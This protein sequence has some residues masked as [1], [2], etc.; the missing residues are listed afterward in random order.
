M[1]TGLTL[2]QLLHYL[3]P[4][5]TRGESGDFDAV[6]L[7]PF[8]LFGVAAYLVQQ[9]DCHTRLLEHSTT[10]IGTAFSKIK[11]DVV[12]AG[13]VWRLV[14][15]IDSV[16]NRKVYP[17]LNHIHDYW[18]TLVQYGNCSFEECL[19]DD[20]FVLALLALVAITDEACMSVGFFSN[21][22]T[23]DPNS[24]VKADPWI[25]TIF[26]YATHRVVRKKLKP[27]TGDWY[28]RLKA[29]LDTSSLIELKAPFPSGCLMVPADRLCVLPKSHTPTL[30]C[31]LRSL[32]Y[33][34][35]LHPSAT[36]VQSH[37][38]NY[39][40]LQTFPVP[41]TLNI[42]IIPYPYAI[43]ADDFEGRPLLGSAYHG[44]SMKQSW[45]EHDKDTL[46]DRVEGLIDRCV[47]EGSAPDI[48]V[49]PEASLNEAMHEAILKKLAQRLEHLIV[50]AGISEAIDH[51]HKNY[52]WTSYLSDKQIILKTGQAKHHR[53]KLDKHQIA[54]YDLNGALPPHDSWWELSEISKRTVAY[55]VFGNG[56]CISTLICEDLARTDPC[57]PSINASAPNL[58]FALLMDGPQLK[59]RWPGRYAL[60]LSDDPGSAVLTV[61]SL[62]LI[63]RSN[64]V[65]NTTS[66]AVAL[67]GSPGDDTR[68]LELPVGKEA[69]LLTIVKRNIKNTALDGR[70]SAEPAVGWSCQSCIGI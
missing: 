69:L 63:E 15:D 28:S 10:G 65:L 2:K 45:L 7:W 36:Q 33:N 55:H 68:E 62:G 26:A 37:W 12:S 3:L 30:G 23:G 14:S 49:F 48:V 4:L 20:T 51:H 29:K 8:D 13:L 22:G 58:V 39:Q 59:G 19:Q 44:F 66:R 24:T 61:T 50:I 40:R 47:Q 11:D 31:T 54:T 60:T 53:W 6:P 9:S 52:S 32:T 34:L 57:K 41:S 70:V 18:N 1:T 16:Q 56:A 38:Y 67:W 5:G 64:R 17:E 25:Q 21:G 35:A 27:T 46:L 42:L 43:S